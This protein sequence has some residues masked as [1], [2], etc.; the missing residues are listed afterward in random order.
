MDATKLETIARWAEGTLVEGQPSGTITTVCTD[1][2]ALKPGDLFLALR[3]EKFD[4][5]TF[6]AE[7]SRRGAAAAIVE[8]VAGG[9]APGFAVIQVADTLRALQQLAAAYRRSL[10]LQVIGI[11]GS[12]GKTTTKDLTACVLAEHFEVT[13]TEGNFNNHIGLPLTMLR[14]KGRDEVGVFEIGMNHPGEIAPLAALAGPEVAI[15]TN[16]GVAHI[17]F[18]GSLEA[19]AQEKGML[20]EALSPSGTVILSAHDDFARSIAARTKADAVF[21][22]IEVGDVQA[23]N[24]RPHFTGTR[25][26]LTADGH[27]VEAELPVPGEHMVRNALLAA[28]AGRVF[29]LSLE[30]CAAGMSK[31]QLTKGRLEHK[32]VRGIQILDDTYNAN[33]DSMSAALRTLASLPAAGRR[34]AVLGAMGE[35]GA[36]TERGHRQVGDVVAREHI[37]ALVAVGPQAEW[38]AET[39]WRG[40]VEKVVKVATND[41]ATRLLRELAKPGDVVLIKGSRSAKM[42]RIVEGLQTP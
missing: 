27:S 30:E 23:K 5:H 21:A 18:M 4:G 31:L 12:T 33:P 32:V 26:T 3:G 7:A 16:V 2:R 34:I 9:L 15:I 36:E 24:L 22:G 40:G 20:A 35:L 42:E 19:T 41:E 38:I 39:A 1:S 14:A 29:G 25:F 17:E 28:A 37:D 10:P 11:T 8:E 6:V 13:K